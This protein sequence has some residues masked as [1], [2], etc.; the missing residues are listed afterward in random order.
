M[1]ADL[2]VGYMGTQ[3]HTNKIGIFESFWHHQLL[4]KNIGVQN[5]NGLQPVII[6]VYLCARKVLTY[7]H[8]SRRILKRLIN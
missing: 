5:P 1:F 2:A 3:T 8:E 4:T 7:F 6:M